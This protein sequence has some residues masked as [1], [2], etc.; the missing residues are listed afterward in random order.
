MDDARTKQPA[1]KLWISFKGLGFRVPEIRVCYRWTPVW[2]FG[3][4]RVRGFGSRV[5][6]A[7]RV[8][9]AT[10]GFLG[11]GMRPL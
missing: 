1:T 2:E 3:G 6:T 7:R 5:L 4:F 9:S 10:R 11:H 8:S